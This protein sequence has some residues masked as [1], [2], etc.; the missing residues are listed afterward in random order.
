MM[1]RMEAWDLYTQDRVKTGQTMLRGDRVPEGLFHLQVHVCIFNDRGELLIQQRQTTKR[2]YAG[3]WDYSVGG[4]A[5]AGDTSLSAAERETL[6]ELGLRVSLA[7]R[8]PVLTR[9]YG[10]MMDDYYILPMNVALTDLRL[11]EEEVLAVRWAGREEVLAL[12]AE[13]RFCPNPPGMIAL[14]FD[15]YQE[16]RA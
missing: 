14:L 10:Q 8:R 1:C 7:G 6:E 15:L 4:S 11:Q 13:G 3:L 12:L 16:E 2:W 9:W 5:V